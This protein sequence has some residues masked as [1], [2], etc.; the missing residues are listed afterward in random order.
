MPNFNLYH[1]IERCA[2]VVMN[3]LTCCK[4][5]QTQS[6]ARYLNVVAGANVDE[7]LLGVVERAGHVE[8]RRERHEQLLPCTRRA[9]KEKVNQT[10]VER[11][12]RWNAVENR[13]LGL[14]EAVSRALG[15][16]GELVEGG[17]G[18]LEAGGGGADLG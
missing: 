16:E 8:G 4:L 2:E 12:R 9:A 18:V 6:C 15:A 3:K 13:G 1:Y 7:D 11:A 14:G 5:L 17:R 10:P